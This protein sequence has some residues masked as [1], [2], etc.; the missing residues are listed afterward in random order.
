MNARVFYLDG[1]RGIL[2]IIVFLHH[3]FYAFCPDLIF[4][5]NY[6]YY[7]NNGPFSFYKLLAL[8]PINIL[9]NPGTAIH[10]FFLLSGYVQT[11]NYF[12]T[13]DIRFL[14]KSIL[15][16]YFRLAIPVLAVVILVYVCHRFNLIRKDLIPYN[17]LTNKWVTSLLPN[18]LT[19][20][21]VITEGLSHCFRG[22]S[23]YYQVLWTMPTE[24]LNSYLILFVLLGLHQVKH[25]NKLL[26]VLVCIQIF[27]LNA[28]YSVAFVTGSLLANLEVNSETFKRIF[29][30]RWIKLLC[31]LIGVYFGSYPFTGYTKAAEQSVYFPISFFEA[32]PHIIS[33][34]IGVTFLFCFLLFSSKAKAILSHRI[35]LFFGKISFMFYLIHFVLLLSFSPRCYSWLMNIH[36]GGID[37]FVTGLL[38]FAVTTFVAYVLT[39]MID[40]PVIKACNRFADF[41]FSKGQN[42]TTS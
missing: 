15:K 33:Y 2:A 24:L 32:Y 36:D 4:G 16:R 31:L 13:S 7:L 37:L 9:F 25:K 22:N 6:S 19:F 39:V 1:L 41:F 28:Y 18:S 8:T 38:S 30:L 3:Y 12:I 17:V 34:F 14:Q 27:V 29:S 23:R 26:L 20:F 10:F 5:G 42:N 11:R 21:N 40:Q 35:F